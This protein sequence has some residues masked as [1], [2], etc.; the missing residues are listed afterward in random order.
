M[1]IHIGS[2]QKGIHG[3]LSPDCITGSSVQLIEVMCFLNLSID[4][5]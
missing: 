2:C 3:P 1:D 5:F 4:Q